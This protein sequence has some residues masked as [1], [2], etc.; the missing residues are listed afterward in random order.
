MASTSQLTNARSSV[1]WLTKAGDTQL[2]YVDV[3]AKILIGTGLLAKG[4][5]YY[6]LV[7][8]PVMHAWWEKVEE[9]YRYERY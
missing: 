2:R 8:K 3:L 4:R 7:R 6:K 9:V 5:E 1:K